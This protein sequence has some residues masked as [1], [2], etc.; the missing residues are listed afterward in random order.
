MSAAGASMTGFRAQPVIA[1]ALMCLLLPG[2][3]HQARVDY[4]ALLDHPG[5]WPEDRA[6][7]AASRPAEILALLE[8]GPGMTVLD[9]HAGTGYF[10]ELLS[11]A[12]GVDGRVIAHNHSREGVLGDEV[13]ERRYGG[14]RLANTEL[15]FARHNDLDLPSA[16][17]DRILMSMVY[18]DTYWYREGVDW[19]PVDRPALLAELLDALKPGGR[20][21]LIDH[22][23]RRG[24]DP[25]RSVMDTHRIDERIVRQDF[26]AAGFLLS[27]ES[28]LLRN[29]D[30]DLALSIFDEAVY[31]RTDRYILIFERPR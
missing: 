6:R 22:S 7:D 12:V 10:T 31:R 5:R 28:G 23:A 8:V 9:F 15:V 29:P 16:S 21:L 19:G 30:D 17:L 11:R 18:H 4:Q 3:M 14:N 1:A 24:E 26:A 20:L 2:C 27:A 25:Y 13:F